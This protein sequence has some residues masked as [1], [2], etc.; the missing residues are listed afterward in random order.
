MMEKGLNIFHFRATRY[1][2]KKKKKKKNIFSYFIFLLR[3]IFLFVYVFV[4]IFSLLHLFCFIYFTFFIFVLF[5]WSS[6]LRGGRCY[7]IK[8]SPVEICKFGR[9]SADLLILPITAVMWRFPDFP[10]TRQTETGRI[11]DP[12][13]QLS[14]KD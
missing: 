1:L 7:L 9:S 11:Q 12:R 14:D 2:K 5:R 8:C 4:F 3:F 6:S 10:K 13:G